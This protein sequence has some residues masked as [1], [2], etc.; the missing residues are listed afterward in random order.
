MPEHLYFKNGETQKVVE[1]LYIGN[2]Y[3]KMNTKLVLI[4]D[5]SNVT[6]LQKVWKNYFVFI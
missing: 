1:V 2:F 6:L 4:G 5:K 3:D